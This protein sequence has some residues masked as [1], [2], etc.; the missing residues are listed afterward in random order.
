MVYIIHAMIYLFLPIPNENATICSLYIEQEGWEEVSLKMKQMSYKIQTRTMSSTEYSAET[1][2]LLKL[3]KKFSPLIAS[4]IDFPVKDSISTE[5]WISFTYFLLIFPWKK[6]AWKEI[7]DIKNGKRGRTFGMM[8]TLERERERAVGKSK[9]NNWG[10]GMRCFDNKISKNNLWS[11]SLSNITASLQFSLCFHLMLVI[12]VFACHHLQRSSIP[13][14][15]SNYEFL[16]I[17]DITAPTFLDGNGKRKDW[18]YDTKNHI[19][20]K[21]PSSK[22]KKKITSKIVNPKE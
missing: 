8:E 5:K 2:I 12:I 20:F 15:F 22:Y 14:N 18:K 1:V 11:E 6:T 19:F 10:L 21:F 3:I 9:R 16:F 17:T 13:S 7:I 4:S